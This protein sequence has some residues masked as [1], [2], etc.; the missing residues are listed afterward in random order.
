[1]SAVLRGSDSAQSAAK[2]PSPPSAAPDKASIT[3]EMGAPEA[4]IAP[5][6]V[7]LPGEYFYVPLSLFKSAI[8]VDVD[9]F[10]GR[11][12]LMVH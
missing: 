1:M 3:E 2:T 9:V 6:A 7:A 12:G 10:R 11:K 4:E 5:E 8:K